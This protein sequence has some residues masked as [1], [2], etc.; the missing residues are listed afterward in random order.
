[1]VRCSAVRT[2]VGF[3]RRQLLRGNYADRLGAVFWCL[4]STDVFGGSANDFRRALRNRLGGSNF[5]FGEALPTVSQH[6]DGHPATNN[7]HQ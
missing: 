4:V 3:R 6:H 5:G 1:M 7:K 2:V